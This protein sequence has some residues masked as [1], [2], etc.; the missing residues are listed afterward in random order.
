MLILK[1][2]RGAD[3]AKLLDVVSLCRFGWLFWRRSTDR[4]CAIN[5]GSRVKPDLR[6]LHVGLDL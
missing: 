4:R 3:A 5:K 2:S 6:K 1:M